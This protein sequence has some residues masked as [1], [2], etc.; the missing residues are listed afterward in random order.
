MKATQDT[1]LH[2]ALRR[3]LLLGTAAAAGL[4]LASGRGWAPSCC[5]SARCPSP[6]S[7][8]CRPW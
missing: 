1:H 5:R 7:T 6:F 4:G 3:R 8:A 2:T